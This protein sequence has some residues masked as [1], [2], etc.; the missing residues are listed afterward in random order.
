MSEGE[1][2]IIDG[3]QVLSEIY[4]GNHT[5]VLEV[6][7]PQSGNRYAMK[8]LN[9]ESMGDADQRQ[10]LKHE[11]KVAETLDHPN[12]VQ[13]HKSV[14]NKEEAY[15][16][17]EFFRSMNLKGSLMNDLTVV[18][19]RVRRLVETICLALGY[20]HE[21]GWLHRDIKPDNI[22]F[23]KASEVRLID[24][25]LASRIVTG[26]SK[27][28]QGKSKAIQGTR[29]YIAPETIRKQ[30]A[31]VHTDIYSLG[32]TIFEILTGTPPFKGSSPNDLLLKHLGQP[33]PPPSEFNPNVTPQM[34]QFVMRMLAKKPEKRHA[35]MREVSAEFRNLKIFKEDVTEGAVSEEDRMR[36]E[37]QQ[38]SEANRLDS[39]ADA[40][41][42]EEMKTNPELAESAR[43]AAEKKA[44]LIAA[45]RQ[46]QQR[47][48]AQR[49]APQP[50]PMPPAPMPPAPMP[51]GPPQFAPAPQ[52]APTPAPFPQAPLPPQPFPPA[53]MPPA[54]VPQQAPPPAPSPAPTP[55][56]APN[57]TSPAAQ[58]APA[59][60]PPASPA[61]VKQAPVRQAPADDDDE[62]P[63]MDELPD[64]L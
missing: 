9:E 62:L 42:S 54:Q 31:S 16:L 6:L 44:A 49:P 15:I 5:S 26:F 22:L 63:F 4:R 30:P 55:A 17:M 39:R 36:S 21:K 2:R 35:D 56:P 24:F 33:A 20:M 50:A 27:L 12:F 52:F 57:S 64:V 60:K 25:S 59:P 19:S 18:H 13:F 43:R 10:A 47:P 48:A 11:A 34:D 23:N 41:R 3:Y 61:P 7:E 1:A 38:L 51:P 58:P 37:N 32:I 14:I 46:A 40:I 8:T 28:F 29:T 53:Q 45:Q